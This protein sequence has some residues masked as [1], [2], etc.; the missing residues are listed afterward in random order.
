MLAE[1]RLT[2]SG[3]VL[4]FITI[5]LARAMF[6]LLTDQRRGVKLLRRLIL[7]RDNRV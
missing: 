3:E 4:T 7:R 5:L 1:P 2:T 6:P